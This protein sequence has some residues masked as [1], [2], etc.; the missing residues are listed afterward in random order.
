VTIEQ[1]DVGDWGRARAFDADVKL[2]SRTA[3]IQLVNRK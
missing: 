2:A 1:R 3:I